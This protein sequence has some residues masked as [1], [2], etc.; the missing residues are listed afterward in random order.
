MAVVFNAPPGWPAPDPAWKPPT[1]WLPDPSWPPAPTGW[2]F[3]SHASHAPDGAPVSPVTG[4]PPPLQ[5]NSADY[6]SKDH[7]RPPWR[8]DPR[9]GAPAPDDGFASFAPET[10]S[11]ASGRPRKSL[12]WGWGG[13]AVS[14]LLGLS[15]GVGGTLLF[16]GLFAF[17]V[18]LVALARGRVRWA[19]LATRASGAAALVA[20]I[21]AMSVGAAVSPAVHSSSTSTL[22]GTPRSPG[23][24]ATEPTP[25][26]VASPPTAARPDVAPSTTMTSGETDPLLA[27]IRSAPPETALALVGTLAVQGRGPMTGYSRTEFGAAWTDIDRNGCDQRNDTLRR[28]LRSATLK[29]GTSGCAVMTGTLIDPYTGATLAFSR[30]ATRSPVQI[31]HVV[32]LADAWAKGASQWP[33]SQRTAFA[34][35]ALNLIA[36]SSTANASKGSGDAATWLPPAK[37]YRCMY[38]ARQV[39]VKAKYQLAVTSAEQ[40]AMVKTL[41][42]CGLTA[43]PAVVV[44]RLGGFP[45]YTPPAAKPTL[46]APRPVAKPVLKPVAKPVPKPVA[47]PV[48][49]PAP[50]PAPKPVTKPAPKPATP[51]PIQGVHPG[52][53]CSPQGALGRTNR[54]TLMRCSFKAGDIRAR[55][56]SA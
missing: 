18:S 37:P 14:G 19:N 35:D 16:V 1:G 25:T 6:G 44:A 51:S 54:G 28:D 22:A 38:V 3:W 43:P 45:L 56:R 11:V 13:L 7:A 55:W 49:K 53:F 26:P 31:D 41:S 47:K 10:T 52:S 4:P 39:A 15:S 20:S 48:P 46:V 9:L 24:R 21:A 12:L 2:E 34:N 27:A 23:E 32:A 29:A 40:T 50:K 8:L 17:V 36:V 5:V 33:L 30:T 42:T